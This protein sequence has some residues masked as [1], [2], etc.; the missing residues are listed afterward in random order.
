MRELQPDLSGNP[1]LF[2]AKK[3]KKIGNGGRK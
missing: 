3:I 2:F 1:F